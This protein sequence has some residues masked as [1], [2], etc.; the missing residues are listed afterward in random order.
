MSNERSP[1][2]GVAFSTEREFLEEY[3]EN[4]SKGGIFVK[5][6]A[7]YELRQ[8]VRVE[9]RLTYCRKQV[10]LD[11]EVVHVI[12]KELESTGAVPGVALQLIDTVEQLRARFESVADVSD[13]ECPVPAPSGRREAPRSPARV[14]AKVN[15]GNDDTFVVHTRDISKS[16]VLVS[17]GEAALEVGQKVKMSLTDP[18]SGKELP[19][20][21]E[22]VRH[23]TA[24][25]GEVAAVGIQF[26]PEPPDP[27]DVQE[28]VD[29][30]TGSEHSRNLGS[31]GGPISE[32]G[33][34]KTLEMF[35]CTAP[36]GT[37]ILRSGEKEG[38][39]AV[40]QGYLLAAV[41]GSRTG[42]AALAEL[43]SWRTGTIN[44]ETHLASELQGQGR[45]PLDQALASAK[46][47]LAKAAAKQGH[48]PAI[49]RTATLAVHP[50]AHETSFSSLSKLEEALIDL[51]VA[52]MR[53]DKVLE[54]I[55][56]PEETILRAIQGLR[57]QGLISLR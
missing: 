18:V 49:P 7:N 11:G 17:A 4:I 56:E 39:V 44:F 27:N 43:L 30:V 48:G 12:P 53:I 45:A 37:L 22:V 41:N 2:L 40:S 31:I 19:V 55:P 52:G 8:Q 54:V 46:A 9:I 38:F 16:G 57:E 26:N 25:D 35:G 29:R 50:S 20:E 34:E 3:S 6:D 51:S 42:I 28:F 36:Q 23:L 24:D 1:S 5:T 10:S 15:S 21:G 47:L 13:S 33:V 14:A 32:F